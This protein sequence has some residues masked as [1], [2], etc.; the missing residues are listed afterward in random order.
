MSSINTGCFFIPKGEANVVY[1]VNAEENKEVLLEIA[2][3]ARDIQFHLKQARGTLLLAERK[4]DL[5]KLTL[6]S[7]SGFSSV[8]VFGEISINAH[9]ERGPI[10]TLSSV[11]INLPATLYLRQLLP[12]EIELLCAQFDSKVSGTIQPSTIEAVDKCAY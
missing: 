7:E 11:N 2:T 5:R 9:D 3:L 4:V 10:V 12:S 8:V 6:R 1:F